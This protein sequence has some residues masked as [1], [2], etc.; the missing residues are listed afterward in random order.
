[1]S[2]SEFMGGAGQFAG[3]ATGAGQEQ[4][5]PRYDLRPLSTGEVLDRT[6]QLYRSRFVLFAGIALLPAAVSTAVGVVRLVITALAGL[7]PGSG[8]ARAETSVAVLSMVAGLISIA[9]YGIV[10]AATTWTVSRV[11]LGE[12]ASIKTAYQFAFQHWFRYTLVM[13][14]QMWAAMWLPFV[15]IMAAVL[16][17]LWT[18]R[19]GGGLIWLEVVL[20][21]LA[22]LSVIYGVWAYLRVSLAVPAAVVESLKTGAAVRRS[23]QLLASRK[24][25]VFLLLLLL[26]ALYL[27]VGTLESPLLILAVRSRGTEAIVM[28]AI[29]LGI[30]FAATTLIGP[31]GVIG[32]CL[33]YFDERVRR[34]GFDIEWMMG[35]L[36]PAEAAVTELPGP[37][38]EAPAEPA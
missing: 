34:E 29:Q 9:L 18:K 13:L 14:R 1:M 11:Y 27:V 6:F 33:F 38:P 28:R 10:L 26:W 16:V 30:N 4:R 25:R 12:A 5:G 20:V 21:G 19:H 37:A 24:V 35:K 8:F 15:L 3:G 7:H 17:P 32:L 2:S 31:V 22:L 23:K 36:A